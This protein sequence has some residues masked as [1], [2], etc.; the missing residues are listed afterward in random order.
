MTRIRLLSLLFIVGAAG[1]GFFVYKTETGNSSFAFK[2][3]LD[4][5]GGTELVYEADLSG[6]AEE[7]ANETMESLRD[8]IERRVASQ[9]VAGVLGVL[10]PLVQVEKT[11][12][13]SGETRHRLIVELPGVTDLE[14]AKEFID[15][16][17]LLEFKLLKSEEEIALLENEQLEE[18]S[19][20]LFTPTDLTGQFLENSRFEFVDSGLGFVEPVVAISFNKEGSELFAKI[21]RENIGKVLAIFLDNE[22]ISLPVVREE[23]RGG[24]AQISG[25]FTREEAKKLADNLNLG[26]APVPINLVGA[27]TIG[28]TLGRDTIGKGVKA[29]ML[30]LLLVALFLIVWYRLPGLTAVISLSLYVVIM[31]SLFKLIPVTLTA[32]GIAGFILSIGMAVDANVIIFERLKEEI[33]DKENMKEILKESFARAWLSI[34]DANISSFLIAL[35]LFYIFGNISIVRGFAVVFGIGVLISMFTAIVATKLFLM[36]VSKERL[37]STTKFIFGGRKEN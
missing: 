21:T 10:D 23:I 5:K 35:V 25:D 28:P 3:G 11:G 14:R 19:E 27:Q 20:D 18:T 33:R 31:L 2:L 26:A 1:L 7:N 37:S 12:I 13:I 29:G 36:S 16:I 6:I 24:Q 34:R 30:G 17:P 4:L 8:V 15:E 22:P 9:N 32:S